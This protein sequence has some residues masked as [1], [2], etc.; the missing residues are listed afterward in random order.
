MQ[1][2]HLTIDSIESENIFNLRIPNNEVESDIF[3]ITSDILQNIFSNYYT[4]DPFVQLE[5]F[6]EKFL[7]N[8]NS[9]IFS[10]YVE[11]VF[12]VIPNVHINIE[13]ID[14][15]H[16]HDLFH[17][18]L[19]GQPCI[20]RIHS[21]SSS[22]SDRSDLIVELKKNVYL[23]I[24]FKYFKT[25]NK[26]KDKIINKMDNL[27]DQALNQIKEKNY[28]APYLPLANDLIEIGLAVAGT[29]LALANIS[30]R[31]LNNK[32]S[33]ILN[34]YQKQL[35]K[36]PKFYLKKFIKHKIYP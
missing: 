9:V 35:L 13:N 7:Q 18:F 33:A 3:D 34:R 2:G 1:T 8:Y 29:G 12:S 28:S 26:D 23:V 16:F 32:D 20:N 14:E 36:S 15:F 19:L 10:Q 31:K 22:S 30:I 24:E 4:D 27:A 6:L 25:Q 5:L 11:F 21:E 17:I